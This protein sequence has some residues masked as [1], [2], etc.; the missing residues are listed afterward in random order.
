MSDECPSG[1]I[2]RCAFLWSHGVSPKTPKKRIMESIQGQVD[3]KY[4]HGLQKMKSPT[5]CWKV[6][7]L[8]PWEKKKMQE[9]LMLLENCCLCIPRTET[10]QAN[11]WPL[12]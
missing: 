11:G 8:N 2:T 12:T 4:L 1:D 5:R 10:S 9:Y 3:G 6:Q 7:V